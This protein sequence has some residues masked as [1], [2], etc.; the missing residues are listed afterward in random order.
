[1]ERNPT[2]SSVFNSLSDEIKEWILDF[3]SGGK[4]VNIYEKMK[5]LEDLNCLSENEFFSKTQFYSSLKNEI[6][7]EEEYEN[8]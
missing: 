5:S 3:L 1:M 7:S 4:G 6:I 8:V 2:Y